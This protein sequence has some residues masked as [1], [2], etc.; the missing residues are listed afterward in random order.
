[1]S[2]RCPDCGYLTMTYTGD[3]LAD[4][5]LWRCS[6]TVAGCEWTTMGRPPRG[7]DEPP[8]VPQ[9]AKPIPQ[10]E[11]RGRV[12]SLGPCKTQPSPAPCVN[13]GQLSTA[14]VPK[15]RLQ[16]PE[17]VATVLKEKHRVGGPGE[18]WPIAR[19]GYCPIPG[20]FK[21]VPFRPIDGVRNIPLERIV[22]RVCERCQIEPRELVMRCRH[23]RIVLARRLIVAMA[24]G[25]TMCSFPD[26]AQVMTPA[27]PYT[28]RANHSSAVTVFGKFLAWKGNR[29]IDLLGKDDPERASFGTLTMDELYWEIRADIV[30][31][32]AMGVVA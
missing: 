1:M 4:R 30:P 22:T 31:S 15:H 32:E 9:K 27:N 5:G 20:Q 17:L 10:R 8:Y 13:G 7:P 23:K 16:A 25:L 26:I 6:N 12:G 29:V 18:D 11:D 28:F 19:T 3:P 24:R 2:Q 14:Q 21:S